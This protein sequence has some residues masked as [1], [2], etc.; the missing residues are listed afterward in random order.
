MTSDE[1]QL[2]LLSIFYYVAAAIACLLSLLM[3][4]ILAYQ[5]WRVSNLSGTGISFSI[6]FLIVPALGLA[7]TILMPV[8]LF[9]GGLFVSRRRHYVFCLLV[10]AVC[11]VFFPIG[12]ALGVFTIVILM[13][14]SVKALFEGQS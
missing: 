8:L 4:V 1:D 6:F 7:L 13:R 12:S 10:A 11:C 9:L 2:R 14:P 3:I 5:Y